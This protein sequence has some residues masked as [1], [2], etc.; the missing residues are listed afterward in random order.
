MN[1]QVTS[2]LNAVPH[3]LLSLLLLLLTLLLNDNPF[4]LS[5]KLADETKHL[6]A[7]D[8]CWLTQEQLG[9][10]KIKKRETKHKHRQIHWKTL[11]FLFRVTLVSKNGDQL[12]GHAERV[13]NSMQANKDAATGTIN[14]REVKQAVPTR[15]L[16]NSSFILVPSTSTSWSFL[17]Y[18]SANLYSYNKDP[19]RKVSY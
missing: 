5:Q 10:K 13:R 1:T 14:C 9:I 11:F 12:H 17:R 6:V 4:E 15:T 2:P 7:V 19:Y 3:H 18:V 16:E 8:R